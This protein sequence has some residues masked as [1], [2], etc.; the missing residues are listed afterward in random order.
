MSN[1]LK[2]RAPSQIS[3]AHSEIALYYRSIKK[4]C[5]NCHAKLPIDSDNCRK[6]HNTD[7]RLKHKL[8]AYNGHHD[9][10]NGGHGLN[11]LRTI[12]LKNLRNK[13]KKV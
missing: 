8:R 12:D 1:L 2:Y 6:C 13:F 3:D 7:L 5:R 4:I 9:L 10:G 11:E